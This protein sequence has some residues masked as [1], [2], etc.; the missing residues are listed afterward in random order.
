[1]K[2]GDGKEGLIKYLETQPDKDVNLLLAKLMPRELKQEITGTITW[3]E[4]ISQ[5]SQD[6]PESNNGDKPTTDT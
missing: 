5:G 4:F 2:A 1:M 3:E 6:A